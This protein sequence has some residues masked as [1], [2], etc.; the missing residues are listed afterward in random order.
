MVVI[1]IMIVQRLHK[2][3]LLLQRRAAR[4]TASARRRAHAQRVLAERE[5]DPILDNA[6]Q[7]IPRHRLQRIR[8]LLHI[9]KLQ[10]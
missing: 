6:A 8:S 1:M 4:V 5:P 9:H 10:R 7:R 2:L 3:L